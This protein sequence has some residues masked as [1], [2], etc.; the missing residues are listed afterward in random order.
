MPYHLHILPTCTN[1]CQPAFQ[2]CLIPCIYWLLCTTLC[3]WKEGKWVSRRESALIFAFPP[4]FNPWVLIWFWLRNK[5]ETSHLTS[6]YHELFHTQ[7]CKEASPS[8]LDRG[9]PKVLS[10]PTHHPTVP[11]TSP[12]PVL[13]QVVSLWSPAPFENTIFHFTT[14]KFAALLYRIMPLLRQSRT[15]YPH[16]LNLDSSQHFPVA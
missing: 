14:Y 12:P 3:I 7:S 4:F 10:P 13:F 9:T 16:I 15:F 6:Q 5:N 1:Q 11:Q 2:S 8:S